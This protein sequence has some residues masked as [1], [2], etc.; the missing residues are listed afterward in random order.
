[1]NE[2][3]DHA[4][5]LARGG[6]SIPA[7][8][9]LTD[10]ERS[11]LVRYGHWMQA[12]SVG[13]LQPN[14]EEQ[15]HFVAVCRGEANP[16]TP[17]EWAWVKL[18]LVLH[19]AQILTPAEL[20]SLAHRL[21]QSREAA[22]A[23]QLIHADKRQLIMAKVQAELD[24]LDAAES[25]RL[26]ALDGEFSRLQDVLRAAIL[27]RGASFRQGRVQAV[28]YPGRVTYD[29]K[30]MEAYAAA[31]PEVNEFKKVSKPFVQLRFP[32]G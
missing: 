16:E 26:K 32:E 19:P 31:H 22:L 23:A 8:G 21:E 14:T 30:A 3:T 9:A 20:S 29:A 4:V 27:A 24:A 6:F 2:S 17:F 25:E 7:T 13:R 18:Q 11:T 28:F 10:Q 5:E 15:R 12:L 1:M